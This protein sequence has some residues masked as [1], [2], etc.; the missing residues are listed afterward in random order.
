MPTR[1]WESKR[2]AVIQDPTPDNGWKAE[3]ALRV[4]TEREFEDVLTPR[5]RLILEFRGEHSGDAP[6]FAEVAT[7]L[8]IGRAQVRA[9]QNS[10]INRLFR[11]REATRKLEA[12]RDYR[13][14]YS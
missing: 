8:G 9:M 11:Y 6:S 12:I 1:T 3:M 5:E 7:R 14:R 2:L 10:A 4:F 13:E